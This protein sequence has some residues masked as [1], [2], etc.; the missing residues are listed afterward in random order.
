MMIKRKGSPEYG[1]DIENKYRDLNVLNKT[2]RYIEGFDVELSEAVPTYAGLALVLGV[3]L[4]RIYFWKGKYRVFA[5]QLEKIKLMQERDLI[6]KGL[7]DEINAG[8]CQFLLKANHGYSTDKKEETQKEGIK[9]E[10]VT[11]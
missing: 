4:K 3:T 5:G 10:F 8:L 7:K 2:K 9:V 1:V 11:V 6:N